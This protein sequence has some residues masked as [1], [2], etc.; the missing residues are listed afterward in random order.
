MSDK[1][2]LSKARIDMIAVL[3]SK[4][5]DSLEWRVFRAIDSALMAM[6][7]SRAHEPKT[8]KRGPNRRR[9]QPSERHPYVALALEAFAAKGTPI[10]TVD[11]VPIIAAKRNLDA[12]SSKVRANIQSG[13]SRDTRIQNVPWGGGR[14]W[15]YADREVPKNSAGTG[16]T[17]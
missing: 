16:K 1:D 12:K 3:D 13:L 10:S 11:I 6:T 5:A 17:P 14:A 15:W 2:E 7:T 4:L 9:K 8:S